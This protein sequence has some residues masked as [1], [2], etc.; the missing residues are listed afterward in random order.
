MVIRNGSTNPSM[1]SKETAIDT[2]PLFKPL[3]EKLIQ[4]L[5]SLSPE[6]WGRQTV[7]KQWK[8]KD[9]AS[10]IL[11]GQ[12]RVLSIQRDGYFG[13]QPPAINEYNDLIRW[14][15]LLNHDWVN[16]TRRLSPPVIILLLESIGDLVAAHFTS[17][18]P[19]DEAVFSV[20]WAGESTSDNRMHIARE[21][22]EF[23]H[24]QQQIRVATGRPGIMTRAFF[25][26]VISTFF[27]A[28]P[29]TFRNV[30]APQGTVVETKITSEA[31]GTWFLIKTARAWELASGCQS[32]P[33][34][35]VTIPAELS[36]ALFSKSIRP[37]EII[38]QLAMAGDMQLVRKVLEMVAVMA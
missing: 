38:D 9:V 37:N 19:S 14:L 36:W 26:P 13:E 18:N 29:H 10:H 33:A 23:W 22:T 25:Y 15:N 28:L 1:T 35:S 30:T 21:Y 27:Q 3:Q 17:L 16:A 20:A 31:G 32:K 2:R 4:L 24:H 7:A 11:D 6:D 12:L 8:V 34:A 5:K